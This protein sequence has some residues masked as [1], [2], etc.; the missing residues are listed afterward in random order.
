MLKNTVIFKLRQWKLFVLGSGGDGGE[1]H[2][3]FLGQ[4]LQSKRLQSKMKNDM[5]D[6]LLHVLINGPKVGRKEFEGVIW[7]FC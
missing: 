2:L 7:C 3:A 5:L 1:W 4:M 6:A